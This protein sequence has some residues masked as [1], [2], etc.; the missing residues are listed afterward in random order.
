MIRHWVVSVLAGGK[1]KLF[2]DKGMNSLV[3]PNSL[4]ALS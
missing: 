3:V 4:L 1:D 2:S